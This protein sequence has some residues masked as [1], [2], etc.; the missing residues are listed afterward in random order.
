MSRLKTPRSEGVPGRLEA[1]FIR[2]GGA[3]LSEVLTL[4]GLNVLYNI[5]RRLVGILSIYRLV[6]AGS[7]STLARRAK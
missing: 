6:I 1:I 4:L 2:S 5:E 3:Y 7:F